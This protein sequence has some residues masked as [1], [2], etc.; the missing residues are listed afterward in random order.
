MP[1]S[2]ATTAAKP[3]TAATETGKDG[4]PVIHFASTKGWE[5]WLKK[6]HTTSGGLWIKLAKKSS[7]IASITYAEALDSALCYGWIDGVKGSLDESYWLQRFTPRKRGSKWSKINCG[8]AEELIANGRM[9]PAGLKEIDAAK[10]DGRWERAYE[11]H[12][13]ITVP[14][15]LQQ[16]LDENPKAKEFFAGIDRTNR[17]AILYRIHDAKKPETRARRIDTFIAMLNEG[18]KLY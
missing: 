13:T 15:D 2:K 12:S 5:A 10:A 6:N 7:G 4:L 8:K 18:K 16:K 11:S 1:T 3:A 17:F 9:T 14:D